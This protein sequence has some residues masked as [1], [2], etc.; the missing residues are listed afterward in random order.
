MGHDTMRQCLEIRHYD[1]I[2][3]KWTRSIKV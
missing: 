1:S 2:G 3:T